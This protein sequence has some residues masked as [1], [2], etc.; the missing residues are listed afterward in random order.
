MKIVLVGGMYDGERIDLGEHV[1][2][3]PREIVR[4]ALSELQIG[5]LRRSGDPETLSSPLAI[6]KYRRSDQPQRDGADV[7]VLEKGAAR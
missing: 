2:A 5:E 4:P 1:P 3:V 7:Y 6:V